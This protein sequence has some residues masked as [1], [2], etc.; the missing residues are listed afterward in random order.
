MKKIFYLFLI[1]ILL[2]TSLS[3]TNVLVNCL[4][5]NP[6]K[7]VTNIGDDFEEV[8]ILYKTEEIEST[9]KSFIESLAELKGISYEEAEKINSLSNSKEEESQYTTKYKTKKQYYKISNSISLVMA[10]K[11]KY[12]HDN[13][14]GK[15]Q[16]ASIGN[17]YMSI[18]G[19]E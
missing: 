4:Y 18:E 15:N 9:E 3:V 16:I 7:G 5:V 13:L 12:I 1:M 10:T 6:S 14:N 2:I 11:V 8:P 19:A 17:A